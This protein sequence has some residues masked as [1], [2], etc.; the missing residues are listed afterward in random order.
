MIDTNIYTIYGIG[1]NILQCRKE[2]IIEIRN[3]ILIFKIARSMER[4]PR[5][6]VTE[7]IMVGNKGN[8]NAPT[9]Y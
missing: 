3:S 8:N 2:E 9:R 5:Q 1:R 4:R 6:I 7:A